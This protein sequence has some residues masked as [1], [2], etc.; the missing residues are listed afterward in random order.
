M[1]RYMNCEIIIVNLA[2]IC[3]D[4]VQ[5]QQYQITCSWYSIGTMTCPSWI[6]YTDFCYFFIANRWTK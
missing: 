6:H 2:L 5:Y 4:F 3:V 1:G